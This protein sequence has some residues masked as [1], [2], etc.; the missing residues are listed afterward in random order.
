MN[1]A[2]HKVLE[3]NLFSDERTLRIWNNFGLV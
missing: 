2:L 3:N 1:K